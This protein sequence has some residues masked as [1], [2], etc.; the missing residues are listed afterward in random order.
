MIT[1]Y[2]L[3]HTV[4]TVLLNTITVLDK[5][6]A[7]ALASQDDALFAYCRDRLLVICPECRLAFEVT[8]LSEQFNVEWTCD[9]CHTTFREHATHTEKEIQ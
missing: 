2:T 6:H 9:C 3:I 5:V 4:V 8:E 1:V 7:K